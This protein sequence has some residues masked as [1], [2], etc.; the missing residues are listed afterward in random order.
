MTGTCPDRSRRGE[1]TVGVARRTLAAEL[2]TA[3]PDAV[4]PAGAEAEWLDRPAAS[5]VTLTLDGQLRGCIGSLVARRS[6][7]ADIAANARAAAFEDPRFAPVTAEEVGRIRVEVSVLSEPEALPP[8]TEAELLE[9]LRPGVDGLVL[10]S[11]GRRA[12]FLPQV[13]SEVAN[14]EDFVARL[15]QKAGIRPG[16]DV[17]DLRFWR[18]R[19]ESYS[20]GP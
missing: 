16:D 13:W 11:G 15:K 1:L 5:F 10:R 8:C 14:S 9:V 20:E 18:Y 3:V 7:A 6:L 17:D 4:E 2:G 12:T 19:V